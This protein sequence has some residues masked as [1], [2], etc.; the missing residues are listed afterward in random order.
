M[1]E[2][3]KQRC[4]MC[5]NVDTPSKTE[6]PAG[7]PCRFVKSY[8]DDRGWKYKVMGGLGLETYKARYQKPEKTG[9]DGWKGVQQ[10]QW[11]KTFDQAQSD[12]NAL[13]EAKGWEEWR[14]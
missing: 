9:W 13:A 6:C 12:L 8:T 3:L 1:P 2:Y 11:R 5:P 10:L 4:C 14:Q 7:F